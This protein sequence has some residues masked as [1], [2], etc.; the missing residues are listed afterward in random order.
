MLASPQTSFYHAS[1]ISE[2]CGKTFVSDIN[3]PSLATSLANARQHRAQT[4]AAP[5]ANLQSIEQAYR[6]QRLAIDQYPSPRTGYKI[7]ATSSEAQKIIGCDG[8]FHGPVFERDTETDGTTL[9]LLPGIV[10]GEAEFAFRI[11]EQFPA[12]SDLAV[13]DM[14]PLIDSCHVAIEIVGRRTSADGL[15]GLLMAIADFGANSLFIPGEAISDWPSI[16]LAQVAVTATIDGHQC[17]CGSGAAVLGNPINALAWLH[18]QLI[19]KGTQLQ[20]GEWVSTGTCLGV[21]EAR[22]GSTVNVEFAG[23]GNVGYAFQ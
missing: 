5:F 23:C 6:L 11:G 10:G 13:D 15:P 2:P 16:D 7:G 3:L 21:I 19:A 4:E 22:S 14:V 9:P 17:N 1:T 8:P 18:R 12:Q 20:A